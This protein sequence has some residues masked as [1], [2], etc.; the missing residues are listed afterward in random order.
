MYKYIIYSC[1]QRR[2]LQ[3]VFEQFSNQ[4]A[5]VL[6]ST[7][8][9]E[10]EPEFQKSLADSVQENLGLHGYPAASNKQINRE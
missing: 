8:W 3:D 4:L 1:I 7:I 5:E 6:Q 9:S 2:V 10:L